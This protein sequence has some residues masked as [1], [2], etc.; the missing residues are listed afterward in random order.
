[1][2]NLKVND[3]VNYPSTGTK[4]SKLTVMAVEEKEDG[5]NQYVLY[6]K[7]GGFK[8]NIYD[9]EL[10]KKLTDK[11]TKSEPK[12]LDNFQVLKNQATSLGV[13]YRSNIGEAK[14]QEKIED[15]LAKEIEE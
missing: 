13:K 15:Y 12:E 8:V 11:P 6:S 10:A 14:L 1:M 3:T 9:S 2:L 7:T 5:N 4:T